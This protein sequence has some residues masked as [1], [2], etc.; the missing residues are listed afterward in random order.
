MGLCG[1]CH[2]TT[3]HGFPMNCLYVPARK[4]AA[5]KAYR[6][7]TGAGLADAKRAVEEYIEGR[8]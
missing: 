4:I 2:V 7:E 5:I 6:E 8:R 1:N 3:P